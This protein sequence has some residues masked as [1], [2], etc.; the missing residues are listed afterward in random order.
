[1][2]LSAVM[3]AGAETIAWIARSS[4]AANTDRAPRMPTGSRSHTPASAIR[5]IKI[6][7]CMRVRYA[8]NRY[9]VRTAQRNMEPAKR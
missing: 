1:M 5:T 8:T 2:N 7:F 9:A 6:I 3:M 4:R